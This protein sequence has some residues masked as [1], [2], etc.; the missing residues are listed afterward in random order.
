MAVQSI[1]P[2]FDYVSDIRL[3]AGHAV[4]HSR[5]GKK[6]AVPMDASFIYE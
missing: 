4:L 3:R 5:S 1:P 2:G 6:V